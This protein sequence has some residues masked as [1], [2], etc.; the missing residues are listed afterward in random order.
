MCRLQ[1]FVVDLLANRHS[2]RLHFFVIQVCLELSPTH[3]FWHNRL[4]RSRHWTL[5]YPETNISLRFTIDYNKSVSESI[6]R[7]VSVWF[8]SH[9]L[10]CSDR[11]ASLISMNKINHFAYSSSLFFLFS[12]DADDSAIS[13][14]NFFMTLSVLLYLTPSSTDIYIGY[15]CLDASRAIQRCTILFWIVAT[16]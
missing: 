11:V 12:I 6:D 5:V 10:E 4:F 3:D 1:L 16:A 7:F 13:Q 8:D 2:S 14:I 15:V 9:R